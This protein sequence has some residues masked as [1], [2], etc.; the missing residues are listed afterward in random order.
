MRKSVAFLQTNNECAENEIKEMGTYSHLH[1][2]M[3]RDDLDNGAKDLYNKTFEGPEER[4][5][6]KHYYK[7]KRPRVLMG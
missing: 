7:M 3:P 1:L 5:R 4:S 2:K 6:S